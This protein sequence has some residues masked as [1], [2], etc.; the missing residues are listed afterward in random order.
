M[1]IVQMLSVF[2]YFLQSGRDNVSSCITSHLY[3][4]SS[5]DAREFLSFSLLLS[6]CLTQS[7]VLYSDNS[8]INSSPNPHVRLRLSQST[9]PV[10]YLSVHL[11]TQTLTICLSKPLVPVSLSICPPRNQPVCLASDLPVCVF[12]CLSAHLSVWLSI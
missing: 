6:L 5:P 10:V 3:Q 12:A 8:L 9:G 4:H 1:T 2:V 7:N 11:S